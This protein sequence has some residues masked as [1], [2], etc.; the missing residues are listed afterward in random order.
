MRIR[1]LPLVFLAG[2]GLAACGGGDESSG[3]DDGGDAA[4]V[5]DSAAPID[6]VSS[7]TMSGDEMS[8]DEMSGDE[9]SGDMSGL[10]TGDCLEMYNAL[11]GTFA[12]VGDPNS[13]DEAATIAAVSDAF[14]RLAEV[15][16]D[17]LSGYV[18]L[19]S[20]GY[21]EFGAVMAEYDY[22]MAKVMADPNAS[23]A[24]SVLASEEMTAASAALSEW[25]GQQCAQG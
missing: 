4:A 24:F 10:L 18:Q 7:D 12:G 19:L 20:E 3:V 22:D 5:V 2:L 1:L 23:N 13:T 16:P 6:T 25:V 15:V 11:S 17:D 14:A 21:A 9:M 8:G